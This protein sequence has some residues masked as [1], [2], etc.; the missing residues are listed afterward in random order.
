MRGRSA[1]LITGLAVAS[2][3][4]SV[5]ASTPATA[6]LIDSGRLLPAFA[7][8][9]GVTGPQVLAE[10]WYRDYTLPAAENPFIGNG[11]PCI[12]LG[13]HGKVL[14]ALGERPVCTVKQGTAVWIIG[15]STTCDTFSAPPYFGADEAAQRAC[16]F[17]FFQEEGRVDA[18]RVTIDGGKAVDIQQRRYELYTPQR[19]GQLPVNNIFDVPPQPFTFTAYGW[20][21][22]YTGLPPG[23]HVLHSKTVWADGS[24]PHVW[25]LTVNIVA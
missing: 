14:I 18:I 16:A 13:R 22:W 20:G 6:R 12:T 23:Q 4:A 17:R 2:L 25:N 3:A 8:V 11:Q 19:A 24:E 21:A 9:D 10:G 1:F 5:V 7:K 15:I